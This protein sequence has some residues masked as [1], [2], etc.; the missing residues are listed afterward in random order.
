[1]IAWGLKCIGI[2]AAV[3]VA[4]IVTKSGWCLLGLCFL[5]CWKTQNCQ[6][7]GTDVDVK[8]IHEP[9]GP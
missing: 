1:M 2:C 5:T 4:V 3:S 7:C 9:D 8:P 6:K